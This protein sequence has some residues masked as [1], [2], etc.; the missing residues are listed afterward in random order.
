[1]KT[2]AAADLQEA[3]DIFP[4]EA[5]ELISGEG[6]REDIVLL[7][8]C[9]RKEYET[10][11]LRGAVN[12]DYFSKFFKARLDLLDRDKTYLVYCRMG[13]RSKLAQKAMLKLGFRKVHNIIGG[14]LLWEEEGLPFATGRGPS[15]WIP[16]PF[17]LAMILTRKVKKLITAAYAASVKVLKGLLSGTRSQNPEGEPDLVQQS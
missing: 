16:C 6:T 1:M 15:K 5:R 13:G 11:H 3:R 2:A 9:T 8:V 4:L 14:T 10:A 17:S 7:D 12:I